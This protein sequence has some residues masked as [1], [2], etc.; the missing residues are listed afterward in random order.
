MFIKN[1]GIDKDHSYC[2]KNNNG[3]EISQS[4]KLFVNDSFASSHSVDIRS[5]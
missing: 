2:Y 3:K 1:I 5:N 4:T